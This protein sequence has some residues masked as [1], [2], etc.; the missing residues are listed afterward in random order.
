MASVR[1]E[2]LNGWL[3]ESAERSL[4]AVFEH[5]PKSE[6]VSAKEELLRVVAD[7]LLLGYAVEAVTFGADGDVLMKLELDAIPPDWGV[8]VTSPNLSPPVD[9][10]FASDADGLTEEIESLLAGVP[11]E[12]ISW[13]D[14]D[15]KRAIENLSAPRLPGWRVSLMARSSADGKIVLDVSF[16]PE[17]PLTLAVTTKIN[18]SSIPAILYSNLREDL[19]KGY[20]PVI[21]VPVSWLERHGEEM[22]VLG[23]DILREEY[24]VEVSKTDPV[25]AADAGVVSNV[26]VE[27]ESRRYSANVWMAVYAGAED[28]YPEV[29]IHLGRRVQPVHNWDLELYGELILKLDDW[30]LEKRIGLRWSLLRNLWLGGE[31]SD[32]ETGELVWA[33][34]TL[35]SWARKPYAWLRYSEEDD[36]NAALG[37]RINDHTS[38]EL[39]Y[40]SRYDDQ[41]NVRA[42]LN[43]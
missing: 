17:Q 5:I 23:R 39:H 35:E 8:A 1:I 21:G 41:W 4:E 3:T 28:R 16:T 9:G 18:S 11:L 22:A 38:I 27:L 10:W 25:V 2:G 12:T 32:S 43:L 30:E 13:G 42:L 33:R 15:L 40:D 20:A 31:W 19:V 34:I 36:I 14:L 29:G 6:P 37:Y 24:L 26:D 7:R